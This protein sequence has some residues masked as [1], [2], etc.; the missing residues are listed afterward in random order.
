M[1]N[2]GQFFQM[3]TAEKWA[4]FVRAE[5]VG[6]AYGETCCCS[7]AMRWAAKMTGGVVPGSAILRHV[8]HKTSLEVLPVLEA[9]G[10]MVSA[11]E[12][13]LRGWKKVNDPQDYAVVVMNNAGRESAGVWIAG[14][15][16]TKTIK[17]GGL[18]I[19][20]DQELKGIFVWE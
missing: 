6:F 7:F 17:V 15:V 5:P 18:A 13:A 11:M 2:E 3:T 9:M 10:G 4:A 12:L 19:L 1:G 14:R 8:R 20:R 16:I